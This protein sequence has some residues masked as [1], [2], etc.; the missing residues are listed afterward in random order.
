MEIITAI[1]D[2]VKTTSMV[3]WLIFIT[4]IVYVLLAAVENVWCWLFG[5]LSSALSVYLCYTGKLFLESILSVFYVLIGIY[6]WYQWVYGSK[7]KTALTISSASIKKNMLFI[8]FGIII[9]LP[10]GVFAENFSSQVLPYLDAFVTAF[11]L[12]AT[13]M[14]AKKII[15]N[16]IYWIIIDAAAIYLYSSRGFYLIALLYFIYTLLALAGYIKWK[17]KIIL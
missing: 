10:T 16:W 13:Y 1:I 2:A 15:Q 12:V 7:E 11:S 9:W 5:I 17:R 8:L 3:E 4:A 6:G 14:T